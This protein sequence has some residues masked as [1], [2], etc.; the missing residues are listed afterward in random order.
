[1]VRAL[2]MMGHLETWTWPP[3]RGRLFRGLTSQADPA[4]SLSWVG[5]ESG[6]LCFV[7]LSQATF[8]GPRSS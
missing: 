3:A 1:M 8:V 5:L 4:A 2:E 6:L 7:L